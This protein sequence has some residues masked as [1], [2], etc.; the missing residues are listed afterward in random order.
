MKYFDKICLKVEHI[1]L[2]SMKVSES[3]FS[4]FLIHENFKIKV[5]EMTYVYNEKKNH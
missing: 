1:C 3:Y 2:H 4:C 5:S